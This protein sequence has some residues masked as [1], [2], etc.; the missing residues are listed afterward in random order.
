MLTK[1]LLPIVAVGLLVF[2]VVHVAGSPESPAPAKPLSPPAHSPFPNTVAG[3]GMIEAQTENIAIGSP[4]AGVVTK[5]LVKVGQRVK[6]GDPLFLL[7]DRVPRA[8]LKFRQAAAAAAEAQLTML[9]RRPRPEE[10]PSSEAQ[11]AEAESNLAKARDQL[12]R[13]EDLI[14]TRVVTEED[15]VQ[16]QKAFQAAEAQLARAKAQDRLL[17][18]GAWQYDKLVASAAV[19][20]AIA[21]IDQVKAD[22]DRLTVRALVDGQVLQVNVRPGEFVAAPA[23]QALIVLGDVDELHARVDIDEHDIP[24]FSPGSPAVAMLR[25]LPGKQ[26]QLRFLRVEPFVVPKKSL[27]GDNTE[28]VDTR[29]LQAIYAIESHDQPLYVGQQL[30]VFIEAERI[31]PGGAG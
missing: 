23:S 29:V 19:D 30:D 11:V 22:L 1:Y 14:S 3:A 2:A 18:A 4:T 5:V 10:I 7:D 25:G 31:G 13:G 21:Q 28:R 17:K 24:R 12:K 15:L 9:E 16:R 27:T 20:Q 26:F 8:E 6:E